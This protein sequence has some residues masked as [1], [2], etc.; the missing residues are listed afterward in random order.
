MQIADATIE[1]AL[2][3]IRNT[4]GGATR[5]QFVEDHAPVG[6]GIWG[7]LVDRRLVRVDANGRI[8]VTEEETET[9]AQ[10]L[11]RMVTGYVEGGI[12]L[13]TD[14]RNG[15]AE[16]IDLRLKR[17]G[18]PSAH[19]AGGEVTKT[20]DFQQRYFNDGPF[21]AFVEQMMDVAVAAFKARLE[22]PEAVEDRVEHVREK[23]PI[24]RLVSNLADP[25]AWNWTR[26]GWDERSAADK[27]LGI[28]AKLGLILYRQHPLGGH[29]WEINGRIYG[30]IDGI[31]PPV[32]ADA[33]SLGVSVSSKESASSPSNAALPLPS[34][35]DLTP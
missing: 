30:R 7:A 4:N 11:A 10:N 26:Q 32:G 1:R 24:E 33:S 12:N 23:S 27:V 20:E 35:E 18:L 22:L 31:T 25:M 29:V 13:G 8:F 9:A 16:I 3:Y 19:K 2:T 15:L 28:M 14:W 21:H 5:E 6:N 34:P 17:L